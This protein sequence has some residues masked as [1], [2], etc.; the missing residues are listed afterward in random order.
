MCI[1]SPESGGVVSAS[2]F[3]VAGIITQLFASHSEST[4]RFEESSNLGV[5][6]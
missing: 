2:C 1:F 3:I 4:V 5:I 6:F